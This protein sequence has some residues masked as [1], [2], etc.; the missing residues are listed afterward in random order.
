MEGAG[1]VILWDIKQ[2]GALLPQE[3]GSLPSSVSSHRILFVE[4]VRAEAKHKARGS[5]CP[6]LWGDHL[7]TRG[8][9]SPILYPRPG[10]EREVS[11]NWAFLQVGSRK[12]TNEYMLSIKGEKVK[13]YG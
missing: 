7:S 11:G 10:K 2:H 3:I 9:A 13:E 5:C 1:K 4:E 6:G 8:A 12:G